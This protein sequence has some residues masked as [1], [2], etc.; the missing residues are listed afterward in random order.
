MTHFDCSTQIN[1]ITEKKQTK[2][3][4]TNSQN[5][6]EIKLSNVQIKI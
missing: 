3:E 4:T 1:D 5:Q 6:N 2:T